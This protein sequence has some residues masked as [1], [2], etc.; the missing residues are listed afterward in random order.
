MAARDSTGRR[1][2]PH[3]GLKPSERSTGRRATVQMSAPPPFPLPPSSPP[4]P[5][6]HPTVKHR[7]AP[8]LPNFA[9]PC[10]FCA[11]I[12]GPPSHRRLG[13]ECRPPPKSPLVE[14][15]RPRRG[16]P[17]APPSRRP[18]RVF[19][20]LGEL[21]R[22]VFRPVSRRP[23]L[24]LSLGFNP[25]W[26]PNLSPRRCRPPERRS[27]GQPRRPARSSTARGPHPCFAGPSRSRRP[28]S[29]PRLPPCLAGCRAPLTPRRRRARPA[30]PPVF[31]G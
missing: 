16:L 29:G 14:H 12:A 1:R 8:L 21:G 11:T 9:S 22:R 18:C 17:S 19:P 26:V 10:R 24:S 4:S 28:S 27:Y 30:K 2:V 5:F 7:A 15:H 31:F 13:A 20:F 6:R 3:A 25:R 23:S